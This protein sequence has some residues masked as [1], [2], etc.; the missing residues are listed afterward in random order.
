MNAPPR[1][2]FIVAVVLILGGVAAPHLPRP[3]IDV[4]FVSPQ[5]YPGAEVIVVTD[6]TNG[7]PSVEV[8]LILGA[9]KYQTGLEARGL[10]WR[11]LQAGQLSPSLK[12]IVD[13]SGTPALVIVSKEGKLLY[14]GK[15]P[16]SVES[17]DRCV[18]E[19]T[20]L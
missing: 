11:E 10:G 12:A 3:D 16:D 2:L 14:S 17:L 8:A 5:T 1:W 20:G 19:T 9:D 7:E 13:K 6:L 18:K 15:L 4:P